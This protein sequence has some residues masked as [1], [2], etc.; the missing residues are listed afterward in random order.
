MAGVLVVEEV[1]VAVGALISLAAAVG[2]SVAVRHESARVEEASEVGRV[3]VV[4][5]AVEAISI[6]V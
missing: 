1:L 5:V 4:L 3:L 6:A 2:D